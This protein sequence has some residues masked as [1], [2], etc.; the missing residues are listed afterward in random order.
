MVPP[1]LPTVGNFFQLFILTSYSSLKEQSWEIKSN[2]SFQSF[3][4]LYK[5]ILHRQKCK[6]A[7]IRRLG[8][9]QDV[10]STSYVPSFCALFSRGSIQ[11]KMI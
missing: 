7:C 10:Y 4:G 5:H 2:Y 3:E 6:K 8:D 11:I 1:C 9:A